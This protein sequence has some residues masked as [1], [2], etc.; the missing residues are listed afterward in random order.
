MLI[1]CG[2]L[3]SCWRPDICTAAACLYHTGGREVVV[4]RYAG[5]AVLQGANVYAPGLLAASSGLAAGDMVAVTVAVEQQ[6]G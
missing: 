4:N 5:E 1:S 2:P 3:C 6:A